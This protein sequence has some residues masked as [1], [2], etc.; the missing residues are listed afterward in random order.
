MSTL[1]ND[2][3]IRDEVLTLRRDVKILQGKVDSDVKNQ[4]AKYLDLFMKVSQVTTFTAIIYG[5]WMLFSFSRYYGVKYTDLAGSSFLI[6]FGVLNAMSILAI[7]IFPVFI[8]CLSRFD[9]KISYNLLIYKS[10]IKIAK[11]N[12]IL[13]LIIL[14]VFFSLWPFSLMLAGNKYWILLP[15]FIPSAI[16]IIFAVLGRNHSKYKWTR[17]DKKYTLFCMFSYNLKV[18]LCLITTLYVYTI[19]KDRIGNV[20]VW[21]LAVMLAGMFFCLNVPAILVKQKKVRK[22]LRV[23]LI[24][25]IVD[26]F[27]VFSFP[28]SNEVSRGISKVIGLNLSGECFVY[29]RKAMN[30]I[31]TNYIRNVPQD[32]HVVKLNIVANIN[33]VYYLAVF[34]EDKS[35]MR[36]AGLQLTMTNCPKEK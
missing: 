2:E 23:I 17:R 13:S 6:I 25:I 1:N 29:D 15:L 19:L 22:A 16:F 9:S 36:L 4:R 5:A 8:V 28:F 32:E 27:F 35:S 11:S 31:P 3:H 18:I 24:M 21:L 34:G 33:D 20:N 26:V 12:Y 7:A 30:R 14:N 10:R